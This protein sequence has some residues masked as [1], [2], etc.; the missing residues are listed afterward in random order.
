MANDA[1]HWKLHGPV[2][3]LRSEIVEWDAERGAWGTPRFSHFVTFDAAGRVTQL[4][5]RGAEQSIHRTTFVYDEHGSLLRSEG[6]TAPGP[7]PYKTTW[8]YDERG[9]ETTTTRT[10]DGGG[11]SVRSRS[12]YDDHGRRTDVVTLQSDVKVDAYS[13]EGSEFGYGAPGAVSQTTRY[14]DAGRPVEVLFHGA[15]GG[16]IRRVMFARDSDGR[17]LSEETDMT[18]APLFPRDGMSDE[19]FAKMQALVSHAFGAMR[20][21]YEYDAAGRPVARVQQM[22]LLGENRV[23]YRYDERGNPI[24]QRDVNVAREMDFEKD[25]TPRSSPDTTRIHDV[26]FAYMYDARGNWTERTVSGRVREDAEF[27]ASNVERRT[28]E[29]W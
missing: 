10:R 26:R 14:D 4:D 6:G 15:D 8:S 22:G 12:I 21:T 17:V 5:Q 28:I 29:Y 23:T 7:Y 9:R 24:E 2:R 19:D 20:T 1:T 18:S 25:G 27:A 16:V 3:S 13:I 11:E